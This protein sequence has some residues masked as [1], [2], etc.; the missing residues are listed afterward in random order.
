MA[1]T[2]TVKSGDSWAKIAG[3]VY[4]NQRMY[5]ELMK[6]NGD[7]N[8]LKP[9]QTIYLPSKMANEDIYISDSMAQ[10]SGM[11]TSGELQ[12]GM[13]TPGTTTP[14]APGAVPGG[15]V[16]GGTPVPYW[17]LATQGPGMTGSARVG[18]GTVTPSP[19]GAD[20]YRSSGGT[21][22]PAAAQTVTGGTTGSRQH[23]YQK[24]DGTAQIS[25]NVGK[26][27]PI[28]PGIPA[29]PW[30]RQLQ[31]APLQG[32]GRVPGFQ[33]GN[34]GTGM[35]G[36]AA[37]FQGA[38][39]NFLSNLGTSSSA[40]GFSVP[41]GTPVLPTGAQVGGATGE[42]GNTLTG[43][44]PAGA[45]VAG[46]GGAVDRYSGRGIFTE[47]QKAALDISLTQRVGKGELTAAD[48]RTMQQLGL[49][50]NEISVIYAKNDEA[51]KQAGLPQLNP[52]LMGG[53]NATT[54]NPDNVGY[55]LFW[56]PSGFS[57]RTEKTATQYGSGGGSYNQN[58][59]N[60]NRMLGAGFS[61][62]GITTGLVSWRGLG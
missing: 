50:Q 45:T 22:R 5:I 51:R 39:N 38:P 15:G 54:Y 47:Q 58:S 10:A 26:P 41:Q 28:A 40:F 57:Q 61:N 14:T 55:N 21:T 8:M 25:A 32:Y 12:Y 27:T 42:M 17:Q 19:T 23:F 59:S 4:G 7:I 48:A 1:E 52:D 44:L 60:L 49:S 56:N 35:Q 36:A 43:S 37:G 9:G 34:Q 11:A 53:N 29:N 3:D 46:Q 13:N 16:A 31:T 6:A 30:D 24:N 33:P 62:S 2:Y 20:R 18:N